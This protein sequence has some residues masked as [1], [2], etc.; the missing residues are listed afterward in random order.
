MARSPGS[1]SLVSEHSALSALASPALRHQKP[2]G[3]ELQQSCLIRSC[4]LP[5][6]PRPEV[7]T[8]C[9]ARPLQCGML[10]EGHGQ[11]ACSCLV[12][13]PAEGA[14]AWLHHGGGQRALLVLQDALC[15]ETRTRLRCSAEPVGARTGH[16]FRLGRGYPRDLALHSASH[17][18]GSKASRCG[19]GL[20]LAFIRRQD[21]I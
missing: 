9:V 5:Q 2:Q 6:L 20:F 18:V 11:Q 13:E 14:R 4:P 16:L 12:Q 7:P 1:T 17:T 8:G 3:P 10:L 15:A 21:L 19:I